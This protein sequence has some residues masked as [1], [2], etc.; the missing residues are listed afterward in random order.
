MSYK[1]KETLDWDPITKKHT[2]WHELDRGNEYAIETKVD[3]TDI[4]EQNKAEMAST[5]EHARWGKP[6]E[7]WAKVASI[8]SHI[9]H[10]AL[11]RGLFDPND[12]AS[13][14]RWIQ[15]RDNLSW[16]T[17]PGRLG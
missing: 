16:R 17:R 2:V 11:R 3:V 6:G 14:L 15:N 13:L 12:D 7:V 8:P 5:D 4:V 10:S 1:R 9:Y